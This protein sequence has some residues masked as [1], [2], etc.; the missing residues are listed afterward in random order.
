MTMHDKQTL[1]NEY[2]LCRDIPHKW[3]S[4]IMGQLVIGTGKY[5]DVIYSIYN[6]PYEEI[7]PTIDKMCEYDELGKYIGLSGKFVL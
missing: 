2:C 1:A 3:E 7:I 6:I 5:K 4:K